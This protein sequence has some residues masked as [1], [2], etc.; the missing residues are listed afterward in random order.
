MSK[1]VLLFIAFCITIG[2][3]HAQFWKV[4]DAQ[5]LSLEVNSEAEESIPVFHP[6]S[7]RLFFVR[8]FDKSNKGGEYDQDIWVSSREN[9]T[10]TSAKNFSE[11]NNKLNNAVLG[12]SR[13]GNRIYLLDAYGGKRDLVKGIS[14]SDFNG[15]SWSTP[16]ELAIPGLEISGSFYG[17]HVN[18]AEDHIII[19]YNGPGSVGEEDLYVSSLENGAWTAPLHMGPVVNSSG[20]EISPF[21]SESGDTLFFSSSRAGSSGGADIY[22]SVRLNKDWKQWT[23]PNALPQPF[24]SEGFDAYFTLNSGKAFWTSDRDQE[25]SDI[26]FANILSPPAL[27][28]SCLVTNEG[29]FARCDAQIEIKVSAGAGNYTY[30]WNDGN[31][32]AY[33]S[34]LC[35]GTYEVLVLDE[36]GQ[37]LQLSCVVEGHTQ[38]VDPV[39]VRKFEDA[40]WKHFFNYNK[41]KI[42]I[43]Q[44]ELK[45]FLKSIEEQFEEG[46]EKVTL[47]VDASASHVPTKSFATNEELAASR[48]ENLK[49]DLITYFAKRNLEQKVSVV[50]SSV[51]V[52]GPNYENDAKNKDKYEA[53]QFV[54]LRSE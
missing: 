32:A 35:A 21:L 22:Y 23:S 37:E 40:E 13:S 24:N 7:A 9:N 51:K 42:S 30:L 44:R 14:Y 8:T 38:P 11:L 18:R 20:F 45:K 1:I 3:T 4:G 36:V 52:D 6:D 19:S 17:F 31:N 43:G 48:A 39:L 15:S 28:A 29:E 27:E 2:F 26:Y 25:E 54:S 46:R 53:F 10:F 34:S 49:Y 16:K 41:N 50:V 33:R 47:V 12:F 5:K